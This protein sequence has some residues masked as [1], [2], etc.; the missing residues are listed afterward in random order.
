MNKVISP[1][2]QI[3]RDGNTVVFYGYGAAERKEFNRLIAAYCSGGK[4]YQMS[5]KEVTASEVQTNYL[6]LCIGAACKDFGVTNLQLRHFFYAKALE[7]AKEGIDNNFEYGDWVLQVFDPM[8][9]ELL[10]EDLLP[11]HKWSVSMMAAFIDFVQYSIKAH[12]PDFKFPDPEKYKLPA[13]GRKNEPVN[14]N[15]CSKFDLE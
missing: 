11:M 14:R 2:F 7:R 8:S 3:E 5:V 10:K 6:H 15:I 13:K 4:T 1:P 9:G 12:F